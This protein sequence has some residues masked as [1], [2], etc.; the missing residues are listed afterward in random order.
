MLS[1]SSTTLLTS[2]PRS[3]RPSAPQHNGLRH[4]DLAAQ[5]LACRHLAAACE[6]ALF[7][8]RA[9][10]AYAT[11]PGEVRSGL[12][13]ADLLSDVLLSWREALAALDAR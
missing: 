3:D 2:R 10:L 9:S 5:R 11:T 8:L 12:I 13:A 7:D 4:E 1:S 6:R